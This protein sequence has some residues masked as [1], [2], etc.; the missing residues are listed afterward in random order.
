MAPKLAN[1]ISA[2][3][4]IIFNCPVLCS[5]IV[6]TLSP[7]LNVEPIRVRLTYVDADENDVDVPMVSFLGPL[8]FKFSFIAC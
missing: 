8:P 7:H 6:V 3:I 5:S 1:Y 2:K 4:L